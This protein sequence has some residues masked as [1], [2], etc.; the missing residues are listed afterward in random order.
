M[1]SKESL[2]IRTLKMAMKKEEIVEIVKKREAEASRKYES[3]MRMFKEVEKKLEEGKFFA[4][5][6]DLNGDHIITVMLDKE[7]QAYDS[8]IEEY[9]RK[10]F[11]Q[12][13]FESAAYSGRKVI[14]V[15]KE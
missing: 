7:V 8:E 9:L 10:I 14:L 5:K 3:A 12:E 11:T 15:L 13:N 1:M 4:E 2:G 6:S